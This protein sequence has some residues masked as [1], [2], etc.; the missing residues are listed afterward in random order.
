MNTGEKKLPNQPNDVNMA[1]GL[2]DKSSNWSR[3]T[4]FQMYNSGKILDFFNIAAQMHMK[5]LFME[6]EESCCIHYA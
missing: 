3:F 6:E 4:H 5:I 2:K 1:F